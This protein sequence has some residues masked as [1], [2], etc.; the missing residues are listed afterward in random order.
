MNLL[1]E[2]Q[3]RNVIRAAG[4]YL[5]GAWL[6][7]QVAGTVLPM[8]GA[9]EWIARSLVI[10]LAIGFLPAVVIAWV[11]ELTPSGLKRDEDVAPQD[12]IAP[13]TARRMDRLILI[14]AIIAVA[15]F[16][17]DKF[18][19]APRR[20]AA[21]VTQTTTQVAAEISAEKSKINP[22]SIAVLPFINMSG[23]K[24]NEYFSDGIS[25]EIL[26]VLAQIPKLQ[27]AARTSS[28]SFKGEHKEVPEIA[29]ELH[30]RMVLEGSVR[31]QGERVR[32]TAQLIDASKG[33]HV[34]SQIYDRD[35]KDIFAIQDEIAKS[36][37]NELQV[38]L[39]DLPR[40][41][42]S[43]AGRKNIE[44]YDAYLRGLALWQ[45]RGENNL[46]EAVKQFEQSSRADLKFAQPYAGLALAYV[47]L[48]DWSV[49]IAYRD[50][51]ALARD[52]AERALSLDP[53]LPEAYV[54]L[55]YLADGDRRRET[56]QAL[57][58][59]AI[60]LRPSY[61]TAYQ[62][63]GNS[64]WSGG[65]LEQGEAMLRRASALDP[66][67]SIIANNHGMVLI[68]MGRF[69]DAE[70]LCA[71]FLKA[72]PDNQTCLELM[73]IATLESGD[74]NRARIWNTRYAAVVNPGAQGEVTQVF[75]ALQGQ[76]DRHAIAV[77][78]AAF[79][80][81][82]IYDP[83]SGNAFGAYVIPSLLVQLG[84]PKLAI[85]NLQ[86]WAYADVAGQSEWAVMMPALGQLHCDPE[87]AALV[88]KIKTTD[89]HY[90]Q[91]CGAK[92]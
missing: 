30:V 60:A 8:F 61:A 44:A 56:A 24:A 29:K 28:F 51:F 21:L 75:D 63:L 27:V 55:G 65:K 54:A 62:W 34:W 7:V 89:P 19:L 43:N 33:F 16:A 35:L 76:G 37:A 25:E 68:A 90:A 82:S 40:S 49:R 32:I 59:R 87:F 9:P 11:F 58:R 52:N 73:S 26:N 46:W 71:P 2:L 80:P 31:K 1:A 14:V 48:P 53:S 64:L 78:L 18:V 6:L 20:E 36:V 72:D 45:K 77:R 38:K 5:V 50:A 91:L 13:Q 70:N 83:N 12:S 92:H 47:I 81:Q 10:L 79:M 66:R 41:T 85:T 84:E 67:S 86:A 42:V 3:R 39:A 15:Y 88:T 23:D 69:V 22:N 17:F 74:F 4:L 57:Y